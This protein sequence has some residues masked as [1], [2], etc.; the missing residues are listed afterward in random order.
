MTEGLQSVKATLA[1]IQARAAAAQAEWEKLPRCPKCGAVLDQEEC[2]TC[3]ERAEHE[4]VQAEKSRAWDIKRLG[5]LKAYEQFWLK[6]YD[7]QAAID[8]CAGFPANNLYLWGPAGVGKT[9][10]ATAIVRSSARAVVARPAQIFR[11]VRGIKSGTEEQAIID[12]IAAIPQ[13][14]IDDIGVEKNTG[15]SLAVLYEII[16][17]RDMAYNKGLIVTSNLSLGALADRLGDDRV[18][19]RL[20]GMCK[21]VEITGPDRRQPKTTEGK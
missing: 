19:S 2:W 14:V 20:A 18:T 21:V 1:E 5:G 16:D 9:H 3:R 6:N 11:R 17:A 15:F 8:A 10:L 4:R 12:R 13:L 7:N